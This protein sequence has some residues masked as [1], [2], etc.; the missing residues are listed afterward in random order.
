MRRDD[1]SSSA[2]TEMKVPLLDLKAQ[3]VV[4][5]AEVR[6]AVDSVC[7]SQH[8]ILGPQVEGLEREIAEYCGTR[9]AIGVSSGSDALLVALMA[10]NVGPGDE[11]ITTPFTFFA[12][13]GAV[14][15][16]GARP[17]FVDILPACF[18]IDPERIEHVITPRTRVIMPVD[19]FGQVC[20]MRR[21]M[22]IARRHNLFVIQDSAQTIG[23]KHHG[24]KAGQFAHVTTFSFFP[25][26]NLGGFGDGGM[27][28]TDDDALAEACR[29]IR[30]HGSQPK[31][32]HRRLG[33]NFRLDALQA[34]VL[35]VKLKYLDGWSRKRRHNAAYYHQRFAGTPVVTPTVY[36]HNESIFN[37]YTIRIR[38]GRRDAVAAHLKE[39]GIGCEIYYPVPLHLQH[40]FAY[41]GCKLGDFPHAEA[42]AREVLS[43]PIYPEL[44]E[45]QL[46]A[47]ASAVLKASA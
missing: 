43:L 27:L 26:K 32:Y 8:F 38:G 24:R 2:D 11:I 12:T 18:N 4:I 22:E 33:G 40:C 35:R 42:A 20:E 14:A 5:R 9:H 7:E 3:Y 13:A 47:V 28:V 41:L 45:A 37:Q 10:R 6:A 36:P 25:S 1:F 29:V 16:L 46:D 44:T 23:G 34:A 39:C 21:I 17:V 15:R 30:V 31:Y 19:L